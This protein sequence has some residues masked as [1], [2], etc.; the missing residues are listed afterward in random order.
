MKAAG[1]RDICIVGNRDNYTRK[2][3]KEFALS[4]ICKYFTRLGPAI[5]PK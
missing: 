3:Q 5:R 4:L 2:R 1:G